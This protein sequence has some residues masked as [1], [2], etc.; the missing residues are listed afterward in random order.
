MKIST[1]G[2]Y[3]TRALLEVALSQ[4]DG[5][6]QLKYIAEKQEIPL[7]YLERIIAPLVK[8][9]FLASTRGPLGGI[10]LGKDPSEIR[11]SE[12]VEALEGS[13]APVAC[14]DD[15]STCP[16]ADSCATCDL[17][18][19]V[20]EAMEEVLDAVTLNDLVERQKKKQGDIPKNAI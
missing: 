20:K 13:I 4:D 12:V 7:P 6:V 5:L 17:W 18:A 1:K 14:V 3:G 8:A 16:R 19:E 11:I 9:G 15:P 10:A 2:R